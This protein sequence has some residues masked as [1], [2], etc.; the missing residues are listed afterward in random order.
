MSPRE[1]FRCRIHAARGLKQAATLQGRGDR[2]TGNGENRR[3]DIYQADRHIDDASRSGRGRGHRI[4]HKQ[5]HVE[6]VLIRRIGVPGMVT[7]AE[8]LTVITSHDDHR[9]VVRIL[10]LEPGEATWAA[11]A[12]I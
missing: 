9:V 1:R 12:R 8:R 6:Q 2:R 10:L 4:L 5:R 3:S 7:L 11:S